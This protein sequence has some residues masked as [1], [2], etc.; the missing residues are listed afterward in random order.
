MFT[1]SL[2]FP[3]R[4]GNQAESPGKWPDFGQIC[5]PEYV[6]TSCGKYVNSGHICPGSQSCPGNIVL[7]YFDCPGF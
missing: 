4:L 1:K 6:L 3:K 5:R 7:K 2:H